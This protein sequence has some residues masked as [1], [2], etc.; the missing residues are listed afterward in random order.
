MAFDTEAR[1]RLRTTV[2]RA[3]ENFRRVRDQGP[4]AEVYRG[5]RSAPIS[6]PRQRPSGEVTQ[7][8]AMAARASSRD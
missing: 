8:V 6:S 3:M 5:P 2:E 7:E 1:E 4:T